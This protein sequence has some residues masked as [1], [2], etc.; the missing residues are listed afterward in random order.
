LG[1][2]QAQIQPSVHVHQGELRANAKEA[3]T[4]G[5][6]VAVGLIGDEDLPRV[7]FLMSLHRQA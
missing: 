4:R 6:I 1:T 2:I 7:D 3:R 5:Q